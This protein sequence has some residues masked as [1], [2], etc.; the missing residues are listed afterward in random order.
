VLVF[1]L[2]WFVKGIEIQQSDCQ[3]HVMEGRLLVQYRW[4]DIFKP[5]CVKYIEP[6]SK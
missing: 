5:I 1:G 6:S 4:S 2:Y 3:R